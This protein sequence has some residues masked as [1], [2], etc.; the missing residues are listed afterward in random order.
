M[1]AGNV[2]YLAG[3]VP[4]PDSPPEDIPT[5]SFGI[6]SI[7]PY[8]RSL[9]AEREREPVVVEYAT[10]NLLTMQ[11]DERHNSDEE[12]ETAMGVIRSLVPYFTK[13]YLVAY[14][15]RFVPHADG[16]AWKICDVKSS[17]SLF[18]SGLRK[19]PNQDGPNKFELIEDIGGADIRLEDRKGNPARLPHRPRSCNKSG[20][21]WPPM[22]HSLR[23][24]NT[25]LLL[26]T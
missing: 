19:S 18:V 1:P 22:D 8:R 26:H 6:L 13:E 16:S 9:G 4:A 2:W 3:K 10:L 12:Y 24:C 15:A 21:L 5:A 23:E 14:V 7:Q 17:T 25:T 20:K 11:A